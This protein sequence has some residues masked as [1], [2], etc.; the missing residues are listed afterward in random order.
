MY[1]GKKEVNLS[2]FADYIIVYM[3]NPKNSI[4]QLVGCP[5][6]TPF[7]AYTSS[8]SLTAN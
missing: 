7:S 3:E 5:V 4:T 1:V 6:S 8:F 2:L